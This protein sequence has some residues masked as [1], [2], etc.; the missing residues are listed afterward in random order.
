M[1]MYSRSNHVCGQLGF[2]RGVAKK[3]QDA[4]WQNTDRALSSPHL[5][6]T[7]DISQVTQKVPYFHCP[8]YRITDRTTV[9]LYDYM[10]ERYQPFYVY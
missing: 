3:Y 7:S 9:L 10:N 4:I 6:V 1:L 8:V 2:I 5:E